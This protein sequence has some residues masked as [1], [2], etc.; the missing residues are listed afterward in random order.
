[1]VEKIDFRSGQY[2]GSDFATSDV[3]AGSR[4]TCSG[5]VCASRSVAGPPSLN[6]KWMKPFGTLLCMSDRSYQKFNPCI[7]ISLTVLTVT[8]LDL[9]GAMQTPE[10]DY[11]KIGVKVDGEVST[12]VRAQS[13]DTKMSTTVR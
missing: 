7:D 2:L 8:S 3:L 12:A 1:M 6:A 11:E 10:P 5:P 13:A 4:G 9:H